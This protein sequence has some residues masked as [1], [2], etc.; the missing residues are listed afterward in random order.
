MNG[1]GFSHTASCLVNVAVPVAMDCYTHASDVMCADMILTCF[2]LYVDVC[3]YTRVQAGHERLLKS[4]LV[5]RGLSKHLNPDEL[6]QLKQKVSVTSYKAVIDIA[7]Q[8][9][10]GLQMLYNSSATIVTAVVEIVV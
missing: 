2:C 7:V 10:D 6:A 9:S 1:F 3:V 5:A 8:Y 4:A